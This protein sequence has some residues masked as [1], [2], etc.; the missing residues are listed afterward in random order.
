MPGKSSFTEQEW[1]ALRKGVTGAGM[2]VST[3]DRGSFTRSRRRE[4]SRST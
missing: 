3:S 1:E 2:L 4:R